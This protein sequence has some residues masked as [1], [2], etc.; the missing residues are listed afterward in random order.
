[1]KLNKNF[2]IEIKKRNFR[3]FS[4]SHRINIT[5]FIMQNI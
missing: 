5:S 1:M 3:D 2:N 4:F